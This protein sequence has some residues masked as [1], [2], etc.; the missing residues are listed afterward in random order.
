VFMERD[1]NHLLESGYEI[2][3]VLATVLHSVRENYLKKV[4]NEAQ[5]GNHICFQGATAKNRALV[6]AFEQRLGKPVYVS[7]YCHLTGAL[8]TAL[9]LHEELTESTSFRGIKIYNTQIPITTETCNLCLNRCLISIAEINGE[10]EAYGFMCGRD[11]ST[12]KYIHAGTCGFDL[13]KARSGV[14]IGSTKKAPARKTVIGIPAALHILDDL[15]F[16]K[17]FFIELSFPV[18]TSEKYKDSLRIGKRMAGAEF[19]APVDAMYG[20]IAYLKEKVDYIFMP[21]CLESRNKPAKSERNYCYYT[22]FSPSLAYL[23]GKGDHEARFISPLLD[24]NKNK[25]QIIMLLHRSL[26]SILPGEIL[27]EH[28][29]RAYLKAEN[30]S[31]L[32]KISFIELYNKEFL[33][34]KDISVVCLGRPYVVL[35]DVLNKGIPDIFSRLGIKAF[36]QDMIPLE[37]ETSQDLNRLIKKIPWHFAAMILQVAEKVARTPR[38]YPVFIT[39]FKCAPDSF[40]IEYFKQILHLYEKPYLIIQIDEHDSNVGYET[41]IEAAIRSFRNHNLKRK[42]QKYPALKSLPPEVSYKLN[43]KILL[44][45][46]WDTFISPLIV[47]NLRSAGI[48]ARLMETSELSIRKSMAHNT[49]QCLPINIITQDYIDYIE[50]YNLNPGNTILWMIE[51]WLSCNLRQYPS[52]IKKLL[53]NYGNGLEKASVYSG[54]ITHSELS[55]QVTYHA[56]FAYM[57]GGLFKKLACRIRPY[58]IHEGLTDNILIRIQKMLIDMFEEKISIEKTVNRCIGLF[59][60]IE[61]GKNDRKPLVAIFGDFYVRD[62]DMMNQNLIKDIEKAGGEVFTTPYHDYVK[63]TIE[64]VLR[65]SVLRGEHLEI[66]MNRILLKLF[67]ILD[68][69]HY[70]P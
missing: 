61:Y 36:Y 43:G 40:V 68:D 64:N 10:I 19:C 46:C 35:S 31:Q 14:K 29:S 70:K 16:W 33:T 3:E 9:L 15:E 60:G 47:A 49:G 2:N 6:S 51:G 66:G 62:N 12:R 52:Y 38:L 22:Q 26:N 23:Q 45:P 27:F 59:D 42:R 67:K 21:S 1:I 69:K 11:Y 7:K 50:A 65:R 39:A 54:Q 18:K 13:L 63:I 41:R 25:D 30:Y 56:Y 5:I 34:S 55:L 44:M 58:E 57:L 32:R 17:D 48:D 20:H 53:N 8:G 24:F 37:K 4:A 28:V